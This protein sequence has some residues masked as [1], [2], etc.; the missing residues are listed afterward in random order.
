MVEFGSKGNPE[1]IFMI[2]NEHTR[3]RFPIRCKGASKRQGGWQEI[4]LLNQTG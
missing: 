4:I 2:V 3:S 1:S